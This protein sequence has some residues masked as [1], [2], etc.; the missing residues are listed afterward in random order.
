[1]SRRDGIR[2]R[3]ENTWEVRVSLGW[4]EQTKQYRR[5][6]TTV[7]GSRADAERRSREL[8]MQRDHGVFV[9]PSR[10]TVQEYL[11][12]WVNAREAQGLKPS[13]IQGYRGVCQRYVYPS[14]GSLPLQK[15]TPI[16]MDRLY[17]HLRKVGSG[18]GPVSER[19][20]LSVH[21]I[22]N[23]AFVR[24][25][26]MRQLTNNPCAAVETPRP[27]KKEMSALAEQEV[28]Q[29][30]TML[31]SSGDP[32]LYS[33]VVVAVTT[34]MRRGEILALRWS[35]IDLDARVLTVRRSLTGPI[36]GKGPQFTEPKTAKSRRTIALPEQTIAELRAHRSRQGAQRLLLGVAY[37]DT[38]LVF[39]EAD[40]MPLNP[41]KVSSRWLE[42]RREN[43][44]RVRFHDLRHTHATLMLKDGVPLKVVSDRLGHSTAV[45]TLD[46]YSH[47]LPGMDAAAAE[48][49]GKIL[50]EASS[51]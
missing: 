6:S 3:G 4:D 48:R 12:D 18:R 14:I 44:V 41:N 19:T 35:D 30:L 15:L 22:L 43:D 2:K 24:A 29:M 25:V 50:R 11:T 42:F 31:K 20:L 51:A 8:A 32:L 5:A 16:H 33:V 36:K 21:R 7:R 1:M 34:G 46:T 45:L 37:Q 17:S 26:K 40:G 28:V 13:T 39:A 10:L 23:A 38:G 49:F 47:V 27:Q 9:D